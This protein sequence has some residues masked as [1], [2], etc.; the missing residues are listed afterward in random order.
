MPPL[1]LD[2]HTVF[3]A[4]F[5]NSILTKNGNIS[6]LWLNETTT[7]SIMIMNQKSNFS[8]ASYP[9]SKNITVGTLKRWI[10]KNS[11]QVVKWVVFSE[12]K[13]FLEKRPVMIL[14][15]NPPLPYQYKPSTIIQ[16]APIIAL[17]GLN[18][19][20]QIPLERLEAL[21]SFYSVAHD[22]KERL[23]FGLMDA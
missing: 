13:A 17:G 8:V 15:M 11:I 14:F 22:F 16:P 19:S 1:L 7:S 5:N 3:A 6:E 20:H 9:G 2:S 23:N 21:H 4:M 12:A 18:S 10:K